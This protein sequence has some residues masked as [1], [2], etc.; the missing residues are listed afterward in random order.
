MS[1]HSK[2]ATIK[3]AK[4]A[5]D[6]KRGKLFS[7]LAREISAAVRKGGADPNLNPVLRTAMEKAR[8]FNMPKENIERATG[9]AATAA[10]LEDAVYE[11]YGPLGVAFMIK[12]LTDNRNRTLA[13]V[14]QIFE[15]HGG[16]LGEAGSATYLFTDPD[17]PAFTVPVSDPEMARRILALAEA[18][19]EHDDVQEVYSNFDIPEDVINQL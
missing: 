17:N 5:T 4:Q 2:W 16:K 13:E 10:A 6:L 9:A 12:V 14:R 15:S 8:S 11:G 3:R 19:D 18:L 7:K 1:G